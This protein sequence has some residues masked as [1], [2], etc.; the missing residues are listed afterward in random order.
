MAAA[1]V[2]VTTETP[3][4]QVVAHPVAPR[5]DVTI[6]G[7]PFTSYIYEHSEKKPSLYPVRSASGKIITRGY[8][9][10]PRPG[11]RVDHPHHVG[12]WFNYGDV[13]GLDFWNNSDAIPA[14]RAAQMGTIVHKRVIK[15]VSGKDK[16]ELNVEMDW[17]DSKGTLLLKEDTHFLFQGDANSRV[18]D[19]IT[20]L[21]ALKE[22]VVLG[23][24]KE[25]V[26]GMRMARSLEQP[27][28]AP[29]TF[30]DASGKPATT[31]TVN[32]EGVTGNYI[33]SDGKTGDAVWGTR[34][35]WTMLQGKVDSE[36]VT[37]AILDHPEN[38]GFPTYWHARG[39][40]L[41]AANNLGQKVFDPKQPE[42]KRTIA[43]GQSMTFRH[44]ILI[45]NGSA[46][47]AQI[48]AEHKK[49][50]DAR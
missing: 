23:D 49:F 20:R 16:G 37:I 3:R 26:L 34:G 42:A 43:P 10:E 30:V 39:Y 35:P 45:L 32:N 27:S 41:F 7:K 33:G 47:A 19:R 48:A 25:G 17:V 46:D 5:V 28:N 15:T 50:A 11:E 6:D 13:N 12:L 18:I 4:I 8:P 31:K 24:N 44:R 2:S 40:G 29:D 9:L 1:A 22:P 36:P 14:A 38:P 21:T